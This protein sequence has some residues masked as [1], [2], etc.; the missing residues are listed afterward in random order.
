MMLPQGDGNQPAKK[1]VRIIPV[2]LRERIELFDKYK[3]Y[4]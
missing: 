4:T 3:R 1:Q 2:T